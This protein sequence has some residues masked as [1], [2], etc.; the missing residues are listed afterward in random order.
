MGKRTAMAAPSS[1]QLP[2]TLGRKEDAP[3][4]KT[5]GAAYGTMRGWGRTSC[6]RASASP[7]CP[8][9]LQSRCS[10]TFKA[11]PPP[12][13][14]DSPDA[15]GQ[16]VSGKRKEIRRGGTAGGGAPT[17]SSSARHPPALLAFF[18]DTV[19]AN[20]SRYLLVVAML[21]QH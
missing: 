20:G 18:V 5:H 12:T 1:A 15:S 21:L 16:A 3:T 11:A 19:S 8:A 2:W 6:P 10:T 7:P 9:A 14:G 13:L 4:G 17:S